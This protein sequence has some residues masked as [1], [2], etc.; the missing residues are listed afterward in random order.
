MPPSQ[1]LSGGRVLLAPAALTLPHLGLA[2]KVTAWNRYSA[3]IRA[4]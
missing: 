2:L 4:L 3:D 1:R